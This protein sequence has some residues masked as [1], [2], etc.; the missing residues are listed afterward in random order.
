LNPHEPTTANI[1]FTENGRCP[2][3]AS[4]GKQ[5]IHNRFGTAQS[6]LKLTENEGEKTD[7]HTG[8]KRCQKKEETRED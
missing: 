2:A 3:I 1:F 4:R 8:P 5:S 7:K 6:Q